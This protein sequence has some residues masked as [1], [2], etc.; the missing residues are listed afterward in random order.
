MFVFNEPLDWSV[1]YTGKFPQITDLQLDV[2]MLYLNVI[3]NHLTVQNIFSFPLSL[4]FLTHELFKSTLISSLWFGDF[5]LTYFLLISR[6]TS[7][8]SHSILWMISTLRMKD[9]LYSPANNYFYAKVIY[10]PI[11][12][13]ELI[14]FVSLTSLLILFNFF[15]LLDN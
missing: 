10:M 12:S 13:N 4:L 14:L 6:L 3:F 7:P 8:Y 2:C 9:R 5:L 15:V 1:I 11:G